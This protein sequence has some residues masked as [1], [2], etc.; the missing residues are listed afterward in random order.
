MSGKKQPENP[1]TRLINAILGTGRKKQNALLAVAMTVVI[2]L[3][4]TVGEFTDGGLPSWSDGCDAMGGS[5]VS[6]GE[7]RIHAIDIGQGDCVLVQGGG[8]NILIDAGESGMGR[9]VLSYLESMGV[10]KLDWVINS[11]PHSDH[12]GG[13]AAV[14]SG[15]AVENVMMPRLPDELVPATRTYENLM[16]AIAEKGLRV[17]AASAGDIYTFGNNGEMTMKVL[18]PQNPS[19]YT[20]L[21][22][23]SVALLFSC[24]GLRFFTA[25][26]IEERV[27]DDLLESGVKLRADIYKASHHGS[28]TSSSKKFLKAVKPQYAFIC[29]GI[30]NSYNHPSRKVVQ[31]LESMG[32]EVERTDLAGTIVYHWD[33]E[34]VT[35]KTEK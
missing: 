21:N 22:D 9:Q 25:G 8:V 34:K 19:P 12:M 5:V 35:V 7:M 13:L 28:N 15:I 33:G 30:D 27:E 18:S 3:V 17:T 4:L 26:D 24:A 32:V 20:E 11:H 31:R 16:E 6:G 1:V 29:C 2:A 23:C 14:I 10:R